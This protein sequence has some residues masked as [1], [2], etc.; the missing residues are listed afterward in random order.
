VTLLSRGGQPHAIQALQACGNG[1]HEVAGPGAQMGM[2]SFLLRVM[3]SGLLIS[4]SRPSVVDPSV[5]GG[6][7]CELLLGSLNHRLKQH[8]QARAAWDLRRSRVLALL[9][10][11]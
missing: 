11:L 9:L 4:Y 1:D 5:D 2:R 10:R 3:T 6:S 7:I 8:S